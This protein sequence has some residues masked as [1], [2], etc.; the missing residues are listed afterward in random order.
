MSLRMQ[1]GA[2]YRKYRSTNDDISSGG[3]NGYVMLE[4]LGHIGIDR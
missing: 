2:A 1:W 3:V 4:E